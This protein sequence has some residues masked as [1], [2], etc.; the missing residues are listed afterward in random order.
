MF[1]DHFMNTDLDWNKEFIYI[2]SNRKRNRIAV[3]S[4]CDSIER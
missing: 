3:N 4:D 2:E 1:Q